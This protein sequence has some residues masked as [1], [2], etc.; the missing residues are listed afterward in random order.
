M[1][2][3]ARL[4]RTLWLTTAILVVVFAVLLSVTR[5]ILPQ[6]E[7]FRDDL[8][9]WASE[10]LG[11]SVEVG[12]IGARWH[13]WGPELAL[14]DVRLADGR[15][16]PALLRFDEVH[17]GVDL[18]AAIQEGRI[19]P[20]AIRVIGTRLTL[21]RTED[22]R[23]QLQGLGL[24]ARQ[25][26]DSRAAGIAWLFSREHLLLE[27]ADIMLV[28]RRRAPESLELND[29]NLELRNQGDNHQLAG[30]LRL[31][32]Q[33]GHT[34]T[35]AL[36]ANNILA[37]PEDWGAVLH[38]KLEGLRLDSL[39][40][41]DP[42]Q[43]PPLNAGTA[44][45]ELWGEL[46]HGRLEALNGRLGVA[47]LHV[48]KESQDEHRI[49]ALGGEFAW[50][51]HED[52]W[53]LH[54][55]DVH[56][57]RSG[58]AWPI[59]G[60]QVRYRNGSE[61][62][63]AALRADWDYLRVE[64][65]L[66]LLDAA[67]SVPERW[68]ELLRLLAPQGVI[69][70]GKLV[71]QVTETPSFRFEADLQEIGF[72]PWRQVPGLQGITARVAGDEQGGSAQ[73]KSAVVRLDA[74]LMFRGPFSARNVVADLTWARR[75][76]GWAVA[77]SSASVDDPVAKGKAA[78]DFEWQPDS[79][80]FLDLRT[81]FWDG[82]GTHLSTYL[83]VGRM[84]EATVAWVDRGIIGGRVT[85]G[86]MVYRGRI[87]SFPFFAKEGRF[88]IRFDAEQGVLDYQAGWP[89]IDGIA[90]AV[91]FEEATM[92][93]RAHQGDVLG[94][95]IVQAEAEVLNLKRNPLLSLTGK[96]NLPVASGVQFLLESPLTENFRD[97]LSDLRTDGKAVLDLTL[98]IPLRKGSLPVV[99]GTVAINDAR[100]TA[101]RLATTLDRV[102]G[103]L[104]FTEA[105]LESDD[106]KGRLLGGDTRISVK[107]PLGRFRTQQPAG[108]VKVQGH[109][110]A[111]ALARFLAQPFLNE[112]LEGAAAWEATWRLPRNDSDG[113]DV[114]LNSDLE[115]LAIEL[116][117]PLGK[118]V[119]TRRP[120]RIDIAIRRGTRRDVAVHYDEQVDA[121][122]RWVADGSGFALERG[123]VRFGGGT[124]RL[125]SETGLTLAGD[126]ERFSV[127]EWRGA[128][129]GWGKSWD[130]SAGLLQRIV[131]RIGTLL[132]AK[133]QLSDVRLS[134]VKGKGYWEGAINGESAKGHLRVPFRAG[135]DPLLLRLDHLRLQRDPAAA[136]TAGDVWPDP[137][138]VPPI[139]V[140]LE[141]F[142][143]NGETLGNLVLRALRIKG[144]MRIA[145][146]LVQ[147]ENLQ[148][149]ASG[150]WTGDARVNRSAIQMR[151]ETADLGRLLKA[152]D[153]AEGIKNGRTVAEAQLTWPGPPGDPE[154]EGL[155]GRIAI[156]I[157][158]GRVVDIEPGAG[159]IFG[160]LSFQAL[161]RRL[162]FDFRD[163]FLK[164]FSF[165][166]VKGDFRING[167][168]AY[169]DNL[170]IEGPAARIEI[171]GRTGLARRDYDQLVTVV[172]NVTGGLPLAG[173]AAGGPTVGAVMLF[174][175][176]MFGK[177]IDESSGV[178]Y[179]VTGSW[180]EPKL[181]KL[182]PTAADGNKPQD[183]GRL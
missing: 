111:N 134:L 159:R 59:G 124:A 85:R 96:V 80:A 121:Q 138:R 133:H 2:R 15:D 157:N 57:V 95:K 103:R 148:F 132:A 65:L 113:V 79:G 32:E 146:F 60:F 5:L 119:G 18:L 54:A 91:S 97:Q 165:D 30:R 78:V 76:S 149:D 39:A 25:T 52:G 44:N 137:Q 98:N 151:L 108:A 125:P 10:A 128:A 154:L 150:D 141:D 99:K 90:A 112:R 38:L 116:P 142:T 35:F 163:F 169:S 168:D 136:A 81:T 29:I 115:G 1:S 104:D 31:P 86:D 167:G 55:G 135:D 120:L 129:G 7:N 4:L 84:P 161:P 177:K 172:P 56:V 45:L 75:H 143:L 13:R 106:L 22:G 42:A 53:G 43:I 40:D 109:A 63:A 24:G 92:H 34:L 62:R 87:K 130:L 12:R 182:T 51:R 64:D 67:P 68:R 26:G 158:N 175:Q 170:Q 82:D 9:A 105:L 94:A 41:M 73:I 140:T 11:R 144:G 127:A 46:R 23:I 47:A 155:T 180:E 70:N 147:G 49:D 101:T 173:W 66:P 19:Q 178:R 181:E 118:A 50:Q 28:D 71:A 179:R 164:G 110:E 166:E 89:R 139:D 102:Q 131:L 20:S 88:H 3:S 162:V 153:Y 17:I 156:T 58:D 123:E 107:A 74:P 16:A 145:R 8:E 126:V 100:V 183:E 61:V 83:P 48:G 93:I 14:F 27:R 122:L 72:Q 21:E 174:F 36:D 37:T 6:A 114:S 160:L 117:S 152:L 176:K 171:I 77:V 69:A 33:W